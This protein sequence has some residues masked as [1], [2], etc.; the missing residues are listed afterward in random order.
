MFPEDYGAVLRGNYGK[1]P[2]SVC[3]ARR[4]A[5]GRAREG[6]AAFPNIWQAGTR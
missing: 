4:S 6:L 1:A 3:G 5:A 2:H